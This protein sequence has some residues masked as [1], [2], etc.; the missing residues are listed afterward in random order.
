LNSDDVIFVET[1]VSKENL[2]RHLI[3]TAIANFGAL[4]IVITSAGV[5]PEGEIFYPEKIPAT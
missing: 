2:V 3:S 5:T 4:H 1:D